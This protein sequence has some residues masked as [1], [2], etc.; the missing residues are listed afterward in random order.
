VNRRYR[1]KDVVN[2]LD[3][4]GYY[5]MTIA[6]HPKG[7]QAPHA[8]NHYVT[9]RDGGRDINLHIFAE[10]GMKLYGR[11]QAVNEGVL[12]FNDDLQENLDN[13]DLVAQ[14]INE[15]VEKYIRDN[16]IDAPA[17]NNIGSD[18][19]PLAPAVLDMRESKITSVI[20]AT[21]FSKNY[22]WIEFNVTNA[23]GFPRQQRGVSDI[24][25]LYFLGLNWMNTWGSGRFYHV[26]RD[27][28]YL[29]EVIT[30]SD[31]LAQSAIA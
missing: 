1:G 31:Q 7:E 13:A 26:G 19:L 27:A 22:D 15:I 24:D 11:L 30:G 8:T 4:M 2:W 10:Q 3:E 9:G 18:Y 23:R 16:Q 21:G 14:Q 25:G 12:N 20:W 28:E 6:E 17:D 29:A 5:Q